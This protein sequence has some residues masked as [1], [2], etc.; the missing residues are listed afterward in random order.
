MALVVT[1]SS[2]GSKQTASFNSTPD[3]K[4]YPY[5]GDP[6][7]GADTVSV[8]HN[9]NGFTSESKKGGKLLF[10]TTSTFSA[11]GSVMTLTTKGMNASGQSLNSVRVYEKQD[12]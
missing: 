1:V 10:T 12:Q 11:D 9:G 5:T 7:G 4:D 8:K 2:N 3:G 6:I